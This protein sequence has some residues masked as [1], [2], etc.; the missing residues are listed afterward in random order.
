M[1]AMA[2]ACNP[3]LVIADEPGTALDVIVQ[4][5]VM[6]L[7]TE[8]QRKLNL[9]MIMITHDL[10]LISE[11]C[12]KLAIMY[13]GKIVEYGDILT[14]FKK[15]LHPYTQG[16]IAAFPHIKAPKHKMN[17][18]P[19]SPPNLLNPPSGCRF[20]PRCSYAMDVCRKKVPELKDI[21]NGH[22]AACH[23]VG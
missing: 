1:I 14:M 15:P 6:K 8:L 16:L 21:G 3:D 9:A 19:G 12:D 13:A 11:T 17:S 5:Q 23:L 20:Y 2:L 22:L 10:S 7:V 4:A 18:I